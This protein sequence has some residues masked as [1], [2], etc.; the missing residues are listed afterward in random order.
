VVVLLVAAVGFLAPLA[1]GAA[2]A[3]DRFR[4]PRSLVEQA[5]ALQRD[6]EIRIGCLDLEFLASLNF[7]VQ[8]DI[9]HHKSPQDALDF[10]KQDL[11]VFLFL[12]RRDWEELAPRVTGPH[13]VLA[14][15]REMYRAGE[16]VV[17]TNR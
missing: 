3:L 14:A 9:Q 7:Y 1:A 13:R 5:G 8:R 16:V 12:P 10:L 2:T 15:H 11:A 4:A 17:V 6:Q